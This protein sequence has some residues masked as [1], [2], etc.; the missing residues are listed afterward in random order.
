MVREFGMDMYTLLYL[1]WITNKDLLYS[2]WKSAQ[3]YVPAWMGG[4][5]EGERI[6]R[7]VWL[8]PFAVHLKLT[9]LVTSYTPVQSKWFLKNKK[10]EEDSSLPPGIQAMVKLPQAWNCS[11]F[12]SGSFLQRAPQKLL[13]EALIALLSLFSLCWLSI[14]QIQTRW[15]QSWV[16]PQ[17]PLDSAV[18]PSRTGCPLGFYGKDCALVC[19]CQ[20][21]ADCDHISGQ[22]T[23]RTGFMGKH[24]EQSECESVASLGAAFP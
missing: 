16:S 21:G 3:G 24:C 15:R 14:L 8:G 12:C 4:E 10:K 11:A 5:F 13:W 19:Q 17:W 18:L 7:C 20:N 6:Y 23:C 1:K 22:C 9:I 2:T